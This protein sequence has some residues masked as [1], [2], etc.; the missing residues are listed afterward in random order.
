M[1]MPE[2]PEGYEWRVLMGKPHQGFYSVAH[3][4][5]KPKPGHYGDDG[6]HEFEYSAPVYLEGRETLEAIEAAAVQ[7]LANKDDAEH[8]L[9]KR[10]VQAKEWAEALGCEVVV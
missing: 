2:P 6:G 10:L 9:S 4:F 5:L 8:N 3:I 7:L 1:A